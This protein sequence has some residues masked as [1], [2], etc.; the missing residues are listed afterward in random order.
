MELSKADNRTGRRI[1][2]FCM[3][4][5]RPNL[6]SGELFRQT[7][8]TK[9]IQADVASVVPACYDRRTAQASAIRPARTMV[10]D[11]LRSARSSQ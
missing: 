1:R 8:N 3:G 10:G 6:L 11:I 5:S 7:M 9:P 2:L 4:P